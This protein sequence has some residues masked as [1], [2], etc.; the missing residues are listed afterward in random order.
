MAD[1]LKN[2]VPGTTQQ[3]LQRADSDSD[4]AKR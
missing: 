2:H 1:W 4:R 3:F